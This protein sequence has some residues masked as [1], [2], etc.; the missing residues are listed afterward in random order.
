MIISFSHTTGLLLSG[1]K[2]ETR[3]IW[4]PSHRYKFHAGM[5]VDAWDK[6]PF[7]GG[8]PIARIV[9]TDDPRQEPLSD[10]WPEGVAREGF[11]GMTPDSFVSMFCDMMKCDRDQEVTVIRFRVLSII[12]FGKI[13]TMPG[14][15]IRAVV[16]QYPE[17]GD[18]LLV[19]DNGDSAVVRVWKKDKVGGHPFFYLERI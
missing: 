7:A 13:G 1:Q 10:I 6:L 17:V 9:L 11:A 14:N 16:S 15:R 3:R 4:K 5:K 2:T 18:R 12:I 19:H 8:R